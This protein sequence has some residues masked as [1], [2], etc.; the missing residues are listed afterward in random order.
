MP[1]PVRE[2]FPIVKKRLYTA[3]GLGDR[4][5]MA[6]LIFLC[7]RFGQPYLADLRVERGAQIVGQ[8]RDDPIF[9][10]GRQRKKRSIGS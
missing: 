5:W 2:A 4:F 6:C 7:R 3:I 9:I 8:E 1:W 10:L